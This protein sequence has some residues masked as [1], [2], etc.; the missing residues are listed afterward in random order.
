[1]ESQLKATHLFFYDIYKCHRKFLKSLLSNFIP[2]TYKQTLVHGRHRSLS[3]T[4]PE[5]CKQ[6]ASSLNIFCKPLELL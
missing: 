3:P 6:G 5:Q 4:L 2:S 1:M